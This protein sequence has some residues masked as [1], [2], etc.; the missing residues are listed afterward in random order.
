MVFTA[1]DW[2]QSSVKLG[3]EKKEVR[4]AL[5]VS[6]R[7]SI[8]RRPRSS[9]SDNGGNRLWVQ[10]V[11]R[12]WASEYAVEFSTARLQHETWMDS[13]HPFYDSPQGPKDGTTFA[14][15]NHAVR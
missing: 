11:E 13:G 3:D 9:M 15:F 4:C 14:D 2:A 5:A 12:C 8:G 1:E 10:G 7:L 6:L